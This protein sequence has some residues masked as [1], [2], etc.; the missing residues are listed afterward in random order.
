MRTENF[1][2]FTERLNACFYRY[3]LQLETQF[4]TGCALCYQKILKFS[5]II[6]SEIFLISQI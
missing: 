1:G 6:E 3:A 5:G 2:I 4:G